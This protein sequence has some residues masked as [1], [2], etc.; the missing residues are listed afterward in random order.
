M[1]VL[2]LRQVPLDAILPET[3]AFEGEAGTVIN[4]PSLE[5]YVFVS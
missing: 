1:I 2:T 4:L 5:T 3:S